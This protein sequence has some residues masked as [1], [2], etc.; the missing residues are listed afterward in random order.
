MKI[1]L[2]LK[3]KPDYDERP[4]LQYRAEDIW[5]EDE[6]IYFLEPNIISN[7]DLLKQEG[8]YLFSGDFLFMAG[9]RQ[10]CEYHELRTVH[11]KPKQ[12]IV[13]GND[14]PISCKA[15]N[16]CLDTIRTGSYDA[17]RLRETDSYDIPPWLGCRRRKSPEAPLQPYLDKEGEETRGRRRF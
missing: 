14:D 16:D 2:G 12:M 8:K 11:A 7:M 1:R 15:L 6:N 3:R 13:A 17:T 4:L 10:G 9:S 5:L